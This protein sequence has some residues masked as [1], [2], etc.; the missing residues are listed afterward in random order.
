MDKERLN[1]R[2][3]ELIRTIEAIDSVIRSKDW[4]VLRNGFEELV[5]KLERQLLAE[6]KKPL[7]EEN[8]IYFLQGEISNA[9]RYDLATYAERLKKELEG[10]KIKLQ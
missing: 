1:T 6:A 10:I 4:Q 3:A 2:R 9:K 8:K 7:I 5:V